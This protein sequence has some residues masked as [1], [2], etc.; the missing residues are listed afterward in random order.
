VIFHLDP[1]TL[2]KEILRVLRKRVLRKILEEI[3]QR[4]RKWLKGFGA[5]YSS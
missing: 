2:R 3:A 1:H 4:W 5:C